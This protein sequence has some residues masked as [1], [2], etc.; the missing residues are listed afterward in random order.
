MGG[1]SGGLSICKRHSCLLLAAGVGR[2]VGD[3]VPHA[4]RV[5]RISQPSPD[6][7][8]RVHV[9]AHAYATESMAPIWH[10]ES[11]LLR[12]TKADQHPAGINLYQ[13]TVLAPSSHQKTTEQA[14]RSSP[15]QSNTRCNL[16]ASPLQQPPKHPPPLQEKK[17]PTPTSQTPSAHHAASRRLDVAPRHPD[18]ARV[19]L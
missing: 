16:A 3:R 1:V 17:T 13:H 15:I 4:P 5:S 9:L 11:L 10:G 19:H 6:T 8:N 2:G 12:L 7:H 18:L 14:T